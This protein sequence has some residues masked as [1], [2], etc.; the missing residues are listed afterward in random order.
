M[1]GVKH[2]ASRTRSEAECPR[3]LR[4]PTLT[5]HSM[6]DNTLPLTMVVGGKVDLLRLIDELEERYPD[7]F[8]EH[9]ISERELSYRAGAIAVIKYLKSKIAL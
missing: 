3:S 8:P 6:D 2:L 1:S 4:H 5:F 7:R 9:N